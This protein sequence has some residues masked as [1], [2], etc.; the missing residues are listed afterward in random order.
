MTTYKVAELKGDELF[1]A[2][3][4]AEGWRQEGDRWLSPSGAPYLFPT[5]GC[6]M[7]AASTA[8]HI[9]ERE[10]ISVEFDEPE[11]GACW[12]ARCIGGHEGFGP[13]PLIAAMRAYVASRLGDEVAL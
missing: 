3:A 11:S 4:L 10:R 12:L 1:D 6:M 13:T 9:I 8:L 2:V 5:L 7:F